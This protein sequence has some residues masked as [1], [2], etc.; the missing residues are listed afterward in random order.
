MFRIDELEG[1]IKYMEQNPKEDLT[2]RE[3][4]ENLRQQLKESE[5]QI[6]QLTRDLQ[7]T[8]TKHGCAEAQMLTADTELKA[9][10]TLNSS[11]ANRINAFEAEKAAYIKELHETK[12][13]ERAE[14]EK[15]SNAF[16]HKEKQKL[17]SQINALETQKQNLEARVARL[18]SFKSEEAS[19]EPV[20][21]TVDWSRNAA[22]PVRRKLRDLSRNT[23]SFAGNMRI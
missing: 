8:E 12:K 4:I 5:K 10:N 2:A 21:C 1:K 16:R 3:H 19:Q 9:A 22:D 7:L 23:K 17:Q 14:Y 20:C 18:E 13:A 6:S 11:L 15:T